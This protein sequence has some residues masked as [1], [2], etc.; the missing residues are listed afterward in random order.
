MFILLLM[1][2][3]KGIY[4]NKLVSHFLMLSLGSL[5]AALLITKPADVLHNGNNE[6]YPPL[7][8]H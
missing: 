7:L 5:E 8:G 4:L 6:F 1:V 3:L 2:M